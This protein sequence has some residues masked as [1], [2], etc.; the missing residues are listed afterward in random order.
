MWDFCCLILFFFAFLIFFLW[1]PGG[2]IDD[3]AVQNSAL[4]PFGWYDVRIYQEAS[5]KVLG[6]LKKLACVSTHLIYHTGGVTHLFM[7]FRCW[8]T[9][10]HLEQTTL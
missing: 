1:G 6:Q 9:V 10:S 8:K 4:A 5:K 7:P 2:W 3:F